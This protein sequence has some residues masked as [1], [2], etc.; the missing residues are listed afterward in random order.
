MRAAIVPNPV[1]SPQVPAATSTPTPKP[2]VM[3]DG[4]PEDLTGL[5]QNVTA[6]QGHRLVAPH[7]GKWMT[8]AG[9]MDNVRSD[10]DDRASVTF[11][12]RSMFTKNAV[13]AFFRDKRWVDRLSLLHQG[14]EITLT[15]RIATVDSQGVVLHDCELLQA[16]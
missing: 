13:Y 6:L 7:L 8:V 10:R 1:T 11:Q 15:G 9:P 2:K 4:T 12:D 3:F 5:F 16:R 14:N